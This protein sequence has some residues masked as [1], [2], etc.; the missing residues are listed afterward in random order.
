MKNYN[1]N[2]KT[3]KKL[4]KM[5]EDAKMSHVHGLATINIVQTAIYR[6]NAIPIKT[7]LDK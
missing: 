7:L 6:V 2:H 5:P 4:K 3:L 1:K